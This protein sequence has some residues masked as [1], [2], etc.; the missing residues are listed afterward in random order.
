MRDS[1]S[2]YDGP[3]VPPAD[4]PTQRGRRRKGVACCPATAVGPKGQDPD[5]AE[6]RQK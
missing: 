2:I 4:T 6:E 3:R 5:R 1:I